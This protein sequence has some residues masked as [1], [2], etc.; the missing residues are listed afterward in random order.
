MGSDGTAYGRESDAV[1]G[2][3][4]NIRC[5]AEEVVLKEVVYR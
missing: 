3:M 2:M 5:L 4:N 1:V